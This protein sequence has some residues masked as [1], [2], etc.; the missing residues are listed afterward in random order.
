MKYI[1][2]LHLS[3]DLHFV[4]NEGIHR[5]GSWFEIQ[6]MYKGDS[7]SANDRTL[8]NFTEDHYNPSKIKVKLA[9]QVFSQSVGGIL[10]LMERYAA[11]YNYDLHERTT[12]IG[13]IYLF[14]G[15]L[16]DSI[17]I[18]VKKVQVNG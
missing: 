5:T 16:F 2:N 3:N 12:G 15:K 14:F 18:Y 9:T 1:R 13:K 10:N 7:G 17:T 6:K 4:D 8:N 11:E